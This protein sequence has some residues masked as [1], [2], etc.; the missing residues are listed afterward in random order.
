MQPGLMK[1]LAEK[2]RGSAPAREILQLSA[3]LIA[4]KACVLLAVFLYRPSTGFLRLM[5]T[6]WDAG[7]YQTIAAQGYVPYGF[8][9]FSPV[10]PGL[11]KALS[12]IIPSPRV[13]AL[14]ITNLLSFIFPVALYKAF[15]FRTALLATLFPT[16]LVFTTIPYSDIIALVLIAVTI[17][18]LLK[19]RIIAA[20]AGISLAIMNSFNLAWTLPSYLFILLEKKKYRNLMFC[21]LPGIAGVLILLWFRLRTGSFWT[22][23]HLEKEV[24]KVNFTDPVS[25][26]IW[27]YKTGGEWFARPQFNIFGIQQVTVYWFIRNLIFEIFYIAGVIKLFRMKD[28][29]SFFLGVYCITAVLPLLFLS[30]TP[31]LSIPRLLLAA[32]PVFLGYATLLNKSRYY[33]L[34]GG[35]CLVLAGIIGIV[36]TYSFFA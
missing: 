36:Q 4:G 32:F 12:Y 35:V 23:F 34:Y 30:G 7:H 9:V 31:V 3:I 5:S 24:W 19:N 8:Y 25:Q 28:N 6:Q 21:I 2:L 22:Y 18:L 26:V 17:L 11:I 15:N 33:F 14:I 1:K 16:Y 13:S 29:F 20:S 10:F 27:L